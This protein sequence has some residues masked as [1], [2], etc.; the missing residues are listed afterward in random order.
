MA[1]V[2][3]LIRTKASLEKSLSMNSLL[4]ISGLITKLYQF[5]KIK[6]CYKSYKENSM[7]LNVVFVIRQAEKGFS[8][9]V[10]KAG[11]KR[12]EICVRN[13][14]QESSLKLIIKLINKL[15]ISL[16]PIIINNNL[17]KL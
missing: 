1:L 2:G 8:S 9:W 4:W 15:L 6:L 17:V 12:Q 5:G 13:S 10:A 14:L 7:T 3:N 11:F 16:W